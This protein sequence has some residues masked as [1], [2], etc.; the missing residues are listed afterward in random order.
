[1]PLKYSK[2]LLSNKVKK[3]AIST[4]KETAWKKIFKSRNSI[5]PGKT[6]YMVV[7]VKT[8]PTP[9]ISTQWV[10]A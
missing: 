9:S 4:D 1:M 2:A 7:L 10:V 3:R 6:G 8:M 5:C